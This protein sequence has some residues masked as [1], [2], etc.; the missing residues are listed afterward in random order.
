M[1]VL[2]RNCG[3]RVNLCICSSFFFF[4]SPSA[5][6]YQLNR[7][8]CSILSSRSRLFLFPLFIISSLFSRAASIVIQFFS[9]NKSFRFC[10]YV[11][12]FSSCLGSYVMVT[13]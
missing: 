5:T 11:L 7:Y 12:C 2:D 3:R 6:I 1:I 13:Y 10:F 8:F 9:S 4:S